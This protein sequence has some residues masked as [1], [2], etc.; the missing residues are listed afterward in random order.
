MG[1][2]Q[3]SAV[4]QTLGQHRGAAT[5]L[6]HDRV[7]DAVVLGELDGGRADGLGSGVPDGPRVEELLQL[8][9]LEMNDVPGVPDRLSEH[10]FQADVDGLRLCLVGRS[11]A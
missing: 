2:D 6:P 10:L 3:P 9:T 1:K 7:G 8:F 5:Q 4:L 11:R